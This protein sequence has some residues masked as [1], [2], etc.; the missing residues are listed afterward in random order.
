MSHRSLSLFLVFILIVVPFAVTQNVSAGDYTF[1]TNL[2]PLNKNMRMIGYP[3]PK[4]GDALDLGQFPIYTYIN[5]THVVD[6]IG[7]VLVNCPVQGNFSTGSSPKKVQVTVR[8]YNGS[9]VNTTGIVFGVRKL[10]LPLVTPKNNMTTTVYM[11]LEV[12]NLT[13]R[14]TFTGKKM[15]YTI[16]NVTLMSPEQEYRP[17]E[18]MTNNA[19]V[20]Y[21]PYNSTYELVV[22]NFTD[23][24]MGLDS[25]Y[26]WNDY[27]HNRGYVSPKLFGWPVNMTIKILINKKTGEGYLLDNG[28]MKYLGVTPFWYPEI[29][30]NNFVRMILNNTRNLINEVKTNPWVVK[31]VLEKA[32]S[33]S[34]I[35]LSGGIID[36]LAQTL[37]GHILKSTSIYLGRKVHIGAGFFHLHG[38]S[39]PPYVNETLNGLYY[40]PEFYM[41]VGMFDL[42]AT[43]PDFR[44]NPINGVSFYNYTGTA[45]L[46]FLNTKNVSVM[47]NTLS[48]A[49]LFIREY[50]PAIGQSAIFST[51][52]LD[53]NRTMM[54]MIPLP[55]KYAKAFNASYL[56][57]EMGT[58]DVF[59]VKY[60]PSFFTP[61]TILHNFSKVGKCE[62][63]LANALT[64]KFLA[65][66]DSQEVNGFNVSAFEAVYPFVVSKLKECGFNVTALN[67]TTTAKT[68]TSKARTMSSTT[69]SITMSTSAG[70]QTSTTHSKEGRHICGPAFIILLT[71]TPLLAK[72]RLRR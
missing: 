1:Q 28:T 24:K 44:D 47:S 51:L 27:A 18:L 14:D 37:T 67:S 23:I 5:K 17:V 25:P 40:F 15:L 36:N 72:R 32:K 31:Q 55:E 60:D 52:P 68:S 30:P 29:T 8:L 33:T 38:F 7:S 4:C 41:P 53:L 59:H 69:S 20:A 57:V 61:A 46:K 64:N 11:K 54:F 19:T 56:M 43:I 66:L 34:N 71:L 12:Y 2:F 42:Y 48:K 63:E 22:L 6:M 62:Y 58:T 10:K 21:L 26:I 70:T 49:I 39:F 16:I 35:T 50:I 65:I 9:V 45:M 13:A 3:F